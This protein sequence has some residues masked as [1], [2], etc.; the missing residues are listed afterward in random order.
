MLLLEYFHLLLIK[1]ILNYLNVV[2]PILH[3]I[4][5][6]KINEKRI[7]LGKFLLYKYSRQ[8]TYKERDLAI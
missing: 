2:H 3:S 4:N 6:K 7:I 8:K 5:M 1:I